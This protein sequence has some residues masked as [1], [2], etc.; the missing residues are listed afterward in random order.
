MQVIARAVAL[1]D[2]LAPDEHVDLLKVDV[3]GEG[4]WAAAVP[5]SEPVHI[6]PLVPLAARLDQWM[7]H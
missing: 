1:Q 5:C 7:S 3:E 6:E 2:V 4:S